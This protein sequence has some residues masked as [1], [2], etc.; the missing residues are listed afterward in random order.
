MLTSLTEHCAG[1]GTALTVQAQQLQHDLAKLRRRFGR[2]CRGQSKVFV[3]LGRQTETQLLTT[4]SPVV[5]LARAAQ[6]P[7]QSAPHLGE[8]QRPRL[9]T[10]LTAALAAHRQ[11]VPQAR[12]LTQGKALS[13]GKIVHADDPTLAPSCKGKSNCPTQFGRKSGLIAA[14]ASGFIFAFHLPVGNPTD[15]S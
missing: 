3:S 11:I 4:G 9:D 1:R 10:Q 7:R 6:T 14:P 15:P 2:Q 13:P 5:G 8:E 12:R